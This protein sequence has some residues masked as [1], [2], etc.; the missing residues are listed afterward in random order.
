MR[1]KSP[2]KRYLYLTLLLHIKSHSKY[3][4]NFCFELSYLLLEEKRVGGDQKIH[5]SQTGDLA[6]AIILLPLLN[7]WKFQFTCY[8][9]W[10]EWEQKHP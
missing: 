3:I 1:F 4:P 8:V 2:H 7:T 9:L 6:F 5:G 10:F